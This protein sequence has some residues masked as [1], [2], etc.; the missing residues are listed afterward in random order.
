MTGWQRCHVLKELGHDVTEFAQDNYH[1]HSLLRGI[2]KKVTGVYLFDKAVLS[3]F[4]QEF[5]DAITA[6]KPEIAWIEKALLLLPETLEKAKK[7]LPGCTFVCYQDDDPFGPNHAERPLWKYFKETI[8]LYDLHYV[9]REVNINE[10][11]EHGA[12]NVSLCKLGY[13]PTLF[14]PPPKNYL[15]L[16]YRHDVSFVGAARDNRIRDIGN[17]MNHYHIPVNVY[18]NGWHRTLVYYQHRAQF[19][20]SVNSQEYAA[21]IWH[22]KISLGFVSAANRNDYTLRTFEIPACRGFLLA[23]RTEKH[24]ELY[25][26]GKEAEFFSSPEE[27]A[28]KIHFYLT[29]EKERLKIAEASYQR[30]IRS[31][32][33]LQQWISGALARIHSFKKPV[34]K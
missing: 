16:E 21:I 12:Q 3:Q 19:Y 11:Y 26:E 10:F 34:Y 6:L 9:L 30:C 8:P 14:H 24:L 2:I 7:S 13:L 23:Q 27:C 25:E 32:Y 20:P 17:L 28:D 15:P 1:Y 33:T 4:N 18:G 5:L 31:G 29:H 22:S